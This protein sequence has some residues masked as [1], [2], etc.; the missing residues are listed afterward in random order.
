MAITG[1]YDKKG[2]PVPESASGQDG[3]FMS[4]RDIG[5]FLRS[6]RTDAAIQRLRAAGGDRHAFESV[7]SSDADPWASGEPQYRYQ[8][9]KYDTLMSLLPAGPYAQALDLGCGLGL[10]SQR[11]AAGAGEVLGLDIAD[12]AIARA[13]AHWGHLP[14]LRFEQGSVTALDPG[15]NGRFDLVV[16]ADT[17][18]YL[19]PLDDARLA[20]L[21]AAIAG[22]LAPGGL[23]VLANHYFFAADPA[24]RLT[25]RIHRAFAA[26]PGLQ[27]TAEYRRPFFL[28]TLFR[29][30]LVS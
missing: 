11:L 22:L 4:W 18:Y 13:R 12:S 30:P 2:S 3:W 14:N 9:R 15:L 16:I 25:R 19:Q 10:L 23:C 5:L 28:T 24:S 26:T 20:T 27:Q 21:A 1:N 7:Y 8:R 6:A 29:S 17:L